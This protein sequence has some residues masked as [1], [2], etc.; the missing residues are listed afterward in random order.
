M[1]IVGDAKAGAM[2]TSVPRFLVVAAFLASACSSSGGTDN[3]AGGTGGQA[4]A[5]GVCVPG[6]S[7]ACVGPGVCDGW[8]VC[9]ADGRSYGEC[10]CGPAPD[11][12]GS[13]GSAGRDGSTGGTTNADSA[14]AADGGTFVPSSPSCGR[15]LMCKG[16]NCCTAINVPGGTFPQGRSEDSAANDYLASGDA[17]ELPEHPATVAS[18]A[19]DKYEVTV[20]RFRKYLYAYV[21]NTASAP[22]SGAGAHPAIPDTGWQ[23]AWNTY[24]PATATDLVA[25]MKLASMEDAT[26]TDAEGANED[27]AINGLSWVEAFAFCIWDGGRLPTEAEWEYAA[28]GG[29]E[30]RM[31]PWADWTQD[32]TVANFWDGVEYCGPGGVRAVAPV[33]SYSPGNGRWGHADLAG[34]VGEWVFDWLANYT[35]SPT[36]DY[37]NTNNGTQR[38]YRGG[39]FSG[40]TASLRAAAR[41]SWFASLSNLATG[42]RCARTAQ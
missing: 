42:A 22:A 4:G 39:S 33:G 34:N 17:D 24:L 5:S 7:I 2:K 15:G 21:S 30:N 29:A 16:E 10:L 6:Q 28:A 11:A 26:W 18:F 1:V 31:Y 12:G 14:I 25:G 40:D 38:V 36:T 20:G 37:A 23:S 9:S 41:S 8:Q 13:G 3:A 19:L 27:K 32:C 35:A